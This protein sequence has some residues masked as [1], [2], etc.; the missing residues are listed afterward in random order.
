MKRVLFYYTKLI[1]LPFLLET[2]YL[3]NNERVY[4]IF[5]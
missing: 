2:I 1:S 5:I 4:Y 3:E